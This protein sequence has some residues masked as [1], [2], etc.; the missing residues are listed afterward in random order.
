MREVFKIFR[1]MGVAHLEAW[2]FKTW[3]GG[4]SKNKETYE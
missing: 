2:F 3:K 1:I 4:R